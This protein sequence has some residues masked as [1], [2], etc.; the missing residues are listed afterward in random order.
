[1]PRPAISSRTVSPRASTERLRR[2]VVAVLGV[3]L[4]TAV[5]GRRAAAHDIVSHAVR[6][7]VRIQGQVGTATPPPNGRQVTFTVRGQRLPFTASEWRVFAFADDVTVQQPEVPEPELVGDRA[8]LRRVI[9]ARPDQ[10]VTIL[11]ER[12]PGASDLF[13]LTVDRCP[14]R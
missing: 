3:L 7:L 1:M 10:L 6:E 8:L 9:T 11:A 2:A 4:L 14:E 5:S 13:V 12:R